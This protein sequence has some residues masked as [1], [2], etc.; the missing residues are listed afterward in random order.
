M[1]SER[2]RTPSRP[3]GITLL[4]VLQILSGLQL[5]GG[6]VFLFV[7]SSKANTP[8]VQDALKG[9]LWIAEK[10]ALISLWLG[11]VYLMLGVSALWLARGYVR[12]YGWARRRGRMIAALAV[13]FAVVAILVL[14]NRVDPGSPWWTIIFNAGI[15]IY[16]G[17]PKVLAYFA[18]RSRG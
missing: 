14:P 12:G 2:R 3:P 4:A 9:S 10:V 11:V 7:L 1:P 5:L 18:S 13:L 6:C 15:I 17:R 8:E 16:L